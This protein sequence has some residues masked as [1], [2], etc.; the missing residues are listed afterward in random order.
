MKKIKVAV[1]G[2]SGIVGEKII[3]LLENENFVS[4]DISLFSSK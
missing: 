1:A 4:N 3:E 2:A